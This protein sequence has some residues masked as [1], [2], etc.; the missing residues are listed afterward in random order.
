MPIPPLQK[1]LDSKNIAKVEFPQKFRIGLS[2]I[3]PFEG[4]TSL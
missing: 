4:T 3:F 1:Q 2:L